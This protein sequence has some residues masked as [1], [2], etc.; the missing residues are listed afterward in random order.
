MRNGTLQFPPSV[1]HCF[2]LHSMY[3]QIKN[4]QFLRLDLILLFNK[5]GNQEFFL[6]PLFFKG[7]GFTNFGRTNR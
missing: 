3:V 4:S 7:I 6:I 2:H 5:I 1:L